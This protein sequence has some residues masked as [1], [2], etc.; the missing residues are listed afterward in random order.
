MTPVLCCIDLSIPHPSLP[1]RLVKVKNGKDTKIFF[2]ISDSSDSHQH[3][4]DSQLPDDRTA[5]LK[6]LNNMFFYSGIYRG[7]NHKCYVPNLIF[8]FQ[9]I[10]K[11]RRYIALRV[12]ISQIL[13]SFF[14]DR[15]IFENKRIFYTMKQS[16]NKFLLLD[17]SQY[18]HVAQSCDRSLYYILLIHIR[19]YYA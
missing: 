5:R 8:Y 17:V 13:F 6:V 14:S 11:Y 12:I 16:V 15:F 18:I 1:R 4:S 2:H 3:L 9:N 7:I 10:L 19:I